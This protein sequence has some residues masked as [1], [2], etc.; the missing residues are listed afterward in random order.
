MREKVRKELRHHPIDENTEV[1]PSYGVDAAGVVVCPELEA[2]STARSIACG[3]TTSCFIAEPDSGTALGF[4]I[5]PRDACAGTL[6]ATGGRA[7]GCSAGSTGIFVA[8]SC[9]YAEEKLGV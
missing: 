6:A 2:V 1:I 5:E 8:C 3:V 4:A 7:N 9:P